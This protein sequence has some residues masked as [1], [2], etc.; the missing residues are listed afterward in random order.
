[1]SYILNKNQTPF[2]TNAF[3]NYGYSNLL[4]L[5]ISKN[6]KVKLYIHIYLID[7]FLDK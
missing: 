1:M 3:M 2:Y 5:L 6:F 7:V 4:I